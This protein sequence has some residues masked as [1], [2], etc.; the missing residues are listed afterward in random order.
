MTLRVRIAAIA[1]L[2]VAVAVL[3]AALGLY[4]AVRSDLR[5]EI[6]SGSARGRER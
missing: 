4:V 1:G 3:A 2:S 5:G 6:D